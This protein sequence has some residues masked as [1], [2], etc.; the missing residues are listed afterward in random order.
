MNR[1]AESHA[2]S[3]RPIRLG[4]R[5]LF[6]FVLCG[7]LVA[8]VDTGYR[9]YLFLRDRPSSPS[10]IREAIRAHFDVFRGHLTDQLAGSDTQTRI[11]P[12]YG[13]EDRYDLHG[14][15]EYYES[16]GGR[17]EDFVV[18]ILGGSVAAIFCNEMGSRLEELLSASPHLTSRSVKVLNHAHASYKQPQQLLALN[19]MLSRGYRPD[20]VV[21]L[22]GF[23][24]AALSAHNASLGVD[25]IYPALSIW[26]PL[27][28]GA[29]TPEE[30]ETL[31]ELKSL[32]R[33][34]KRIVNRVVRLRLHW[35]AILGTLTE[36][37]VL[38]M[39]SRY[40]RKYTRLIT[41]LPAQR[42]DQ[43]EFGPRYQ[44]SLDVAMA[45]ALRTW[46]E[47]SFSLHAI[48][49]SRGIL[50]LHALQPTLHDPGS[51]PLT[52]EEKRAGRTLPSWIEGVERAYPLFREEGIRMDA[53]GLAFLDLSQAF[54]N[55]TSTLYYD[56][57]HFERP[58]SEILVRPLAERLLRMIDH[59]A[60]SPETS[61][62][63]D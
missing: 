24:E 2:V 13:F 4:R 30:E 40:L 58:G 17:S 52:D 32:K 48:C 37:K 54:A 7:F 44:G 27:V 62:K 5:I 19:L 60:R 42:R 29:F 25:P 23:N 12:Y 22:D 31:Y 53:T 57:C 9:A 45:E 51:K 10:A 59:D 20:L 41:L 55:E 36:S 26:A 46:R 21:N 16:R 34:A 50:Y 61:P 3:P 39:R 43:P 47:S 63:R 49:S 35:S 11:H 15:L 28:T 8:G 1:P 33:E 14:I 56:C 38:R 6:V 18:L